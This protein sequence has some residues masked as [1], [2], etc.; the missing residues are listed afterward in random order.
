MKQYF[1]PIKD[2]SG[3][4]IEALMSAP[5]M[6]QDDG[7]LFKIRLSV[8]EAV[9][10]VVQYAYANGDGYLEVSA[11]KNDTGLLT[12]T[13]KDAG[14]PFDPLAKDDPDVTLALEDRQIGGLGIFLTKQMMDDVFYK[15]Q[16]GCNIL[17]MTKQCN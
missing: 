15:Y 4:I 3:V 17:T 6:P 2:K 10:N 7:L 5:E 9:E 8:E 11:E 1:N 16:D 13:L 14:I 12:I